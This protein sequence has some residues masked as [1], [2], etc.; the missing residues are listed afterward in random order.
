MVRVAAAAVGRNNHGG[1]MKRRIATVAMAVGLLGAA[2]GTTAHAESEDRVVLTVGLV[3]D[4]DSPNVTAGYLVSSFEIY[5]L[6]YATL[7]DKAVDDL[8]I[9][10]GLAESWE[11]S[12]DGLTYTYTLREGLT[13]SD[14]EPL[15]AEDVAWT[16]NTSRDQE[17]LNHSATTANLTATAIDD[18]TVEITSSVPD[19]KFPAMDVYIVPK[20]IW[21]PVA[22]DAT[23]VTTYDASENQ[24]G[25]GPYTLRKWTAGQNFVMEANPNYWKGEAQVDEIVFRIFTEGSAMVQALE[26]GEIDFAHDIPAEAYERL[27]DVEGIVTVAGTQGGFTELAMNG[28]AGGLGDG[29]PAL[30][31]VNVRHAVGHAIDRQ[32]LFDRVL[33]GQGI[34]SDVLGVS[35]DPEFIP[36]VPDDIKIDYD[37]DKARQLLDDGGY[38]DTDGNGIRE[39]PGG[40]EELTFRYAERSES[41]QAKP[42]REFVTSWLAEIGIGTEVSVFDDTQLTDVIASGEYDLFSWGWSPYVDPDTM[43]SYFTCD[44]V[45]YDVEAV[46]WNDANWCDSEYDEMYVAQNQ[47][48]DRE[49]RVA[50]VHEM[51]LKFYTDSTYVVLY[52]DADTQAYR[53]D[54]FEGW[55]QQP[56]ET[57]PVLFTNT[58]PTYFNLSPIEGAD[59]GGGMSTGLII[60]IVAAAVIV[61]GGGGGAQAEVTV[62]GRRSQNDD[63]V[64]PGTSTV[65]GSDS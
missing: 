62:E 52:H 54:R 25:S 6:Q 23:A 19:P 39:M 14:G 18:R 36:E 13:W 4:V 3:Q 12:D 55:L 7:T 64:M 60:A 22:T 24:V 49:A 32:E 48:L 37:P 1:L 38:L 50:L 47:E 45:T 65:N 26:S 28:M 41:V 43:L 10:P 42:I 57:G 34:M 16:V 53:T 29:H 21:E 40:G 61:I 17:W 31:D 27:S 30:Q 56:A 46:G 59:S 9:E 5:N 44:Q 58:S 8:A 63:R 33:L 20:H 2:I 15:T 35:V 51:V 11:A